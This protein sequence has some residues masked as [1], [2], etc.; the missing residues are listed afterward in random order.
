MRACTLT[1]T[2]MH[3]PLAG[4]AVVGGGGDSHSR[5][6]PLSLEIFLHECS[7]HGIR[8]IKM[9]QVI[10]CLH[11]GKK[12]MVGKTFRLSLDQRLSNCVVLG[13]AALPEDLLKMQMI[14]L[15]PGIRSSGVG[16]SD[17]DSSKTSR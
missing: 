4:S 1:W 11:R 2:S 3:R 5:G 12:C 16:S 6:S 14:R 10:G 17:L 8:I 15:Q 9:S 7:T 13:P